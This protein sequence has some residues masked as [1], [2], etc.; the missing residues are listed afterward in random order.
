MIEIPSH[1]VA[2]SPVKPKARTKKMLRD[3]EWNGAQGLA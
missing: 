2:E 1:V 3:R